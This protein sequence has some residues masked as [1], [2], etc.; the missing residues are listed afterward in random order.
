MASDR[1]SLQRALLTVTTVLLVV[2]LVALDAGRGNP[3]PLASV[4]S[5]DD[6][7]TGVAGC[8][9]CHGDDSTT[10]AEAC[11][12]C[13]DVI[14]RQ[15]ARGEG[16]HG[17]L[18]GA[19]ACGACH[20]EHSGADFELAGAHSFERI[21][22]D[23]VASFTHA[24]AGLDLAGRH[25]ELACERCHEHAHAVVL[26]T[27]CSRFLGLE[28]TCTACHDD[29]HA[30][31]YTDDCASCH[32]QERPFEE[33]ATFDHEAS[34]PLSGAHEEA[35]CVACHAE[36]SDRGLHALLDP[37][38]TAP[39]ELLTRT[40]AECHESP[41]GEAL[42]VAWSQRSASALGDDCGA[43]HLAKHHA[44]VGPLARATM[45]P[46]LH[47]PT[48]F[49]LVPPH[50]GLACEQCHEDG[51][52]MVEREPRSPDSCQACHGDPHGDDFSRGPFAGWSCLDCHERHTFDP[53]T[54][55]A[56][57]HALT[58]FA[59]TGAH[60]RAA[61]SACHEAELADLDAAP[62]SFSG[63]TSD[64]ASCHTDVHGGAFDHAS[65]PALFEA[66]SGCARCH[67]TETFRAILDAPFDHARWARFPL[68]DAHALAGCEACHTA[69]EQ[70][71]DI[72]RHHAPARGRSCVACHADP[73]GGQFE[74]DRFAAQ[75]CASCHDEQR[76]F[77]PR[78]SIA[79]HDR[80]TDFPLTGAHAAVACTSCHEIPAGEDQRR[81]RGTPRACEA[82]HEDPHDG[83]FDAPGLPVA[84]AGRAG[85]QRCHET[86]S[87]AD[88][89]SFDH[90][91]WTGYALVGAHA[92]ASCQSCHA[93]APDGA[94]RLGPAPSTSCADCHVD[95]H[96]GQFRRVGPHRLR[97]LPRELR[98]LPRVVRSRS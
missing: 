39:V 67:D 96:A 22:L 4:H 74:E 8:E 88:L 45:T 25:D 51:A 66:R 92:R 81:F 61:C 70:P 19:G 75:G 47:A 14:E 77:P 50:A 31:A 82:C 89:G 43:C 10:M 32:G 27:G 54:L 18:D 79:E 46:E 65:L 59:L 1:K 58:A 83:T 38:R 40:C 84:V 21:G 5:R 87:F 11:F 42:R 86:G 90:G 98:D 94:R 97:A 34:F 35:S 2:S 57:D 44:F 64:C 23:D 33:V 95:P 78:F 36:G 48:G 91:L 73:H 16:L 12:A 55:D 56:T 62:R 26:P 6:S 7:L 29:P 71:D 20:P 53:A 93:P 17:N 3:G 41:H 30:G 85:C 63:L 13:H 52:S 69:L 80:L 72:G 68:K 37:T 49:A 28:A 9:R 15:V 24:L 76:F 60:T